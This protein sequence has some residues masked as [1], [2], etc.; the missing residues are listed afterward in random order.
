M[1]D[2]YLGKKM[3]EY[4]ARAAVN[5]R[6]PAASLGRLLMKTN[7]FR[8]FDPNFE[9]REDQ[10][11]RIIEVNTGILSIRNRQALRFRPVT[12]GEAAAVLELIHEGAA[13]A[14]RPLP[15]G[16]EP[17][18][19][20]VVCSAADE[21]RYI[22][23]DLGISLQTMMLQAAE[24]GLNGLRIDDFDRTRISETLDLESEP[25]LIIAVGK[26]IDKNRRAEP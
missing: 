8:G 17:N 10:L 25:L 1:A 16:F 7:D 20:I 18:A 3:E 15:H 24:I 23:I 22:D 14:I 12:A 19:F 21:D 5:I 13:S 6:R 26:G 4:R 9:V 11:K 2:D